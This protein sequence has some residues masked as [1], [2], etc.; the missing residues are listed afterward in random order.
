MVI[1]QIKSEKVSK[2]VWLLFFTYMVLRILNSIVKVLDNFSFISDC[3]IFDCNYYVYIHICLYKF[4]AHNILRCSYFLSGCS[5]Q[6][7][8]FL[9]Q[10][11]FV[12]SHVRFKMIMEANLCTSSYL[13]RAKCKIAKESTCS[14]GKKNFGLESWC[15][16]LEQRL[17]RVKGNKMG[18]LLRRLQRPHP[19]STDHGPAWMAPRWKQKRAWSHDHI[20][21]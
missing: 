10:F 15:L 11:S 16:E 18:I 9:P 6:W 19:D 12:N 8:R 2:V 1:W 13:L 7:K 14:N 17:H 3:C 5:S 21:L 4:V 20:S